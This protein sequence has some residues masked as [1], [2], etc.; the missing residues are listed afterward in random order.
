MSM[1]ARDTE[2]YRI[3]FITA[4]LST[5]PDSI[6]SHRRSKLLR[7]SEC[8]VLDVIACE[9]V[10]LAL[11]LFKDVSAVLSCL[12]FDDMT[13]RLL[14]SLFHYF[15]AQTFTFLLDQVREATL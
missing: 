8:T 7:K 4:K 11:N 13:N 10:A 5:T 14:E 3:D 9:E 1:P 2:S 6:M 12:I 15:Y